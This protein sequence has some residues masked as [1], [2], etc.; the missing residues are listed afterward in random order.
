MLQWHKGI[1]TAIITYVL[2]IIFSLILLWQEKI[3]L[4]VIAVILFTVITIGI[5]FDIIG[6]AATAATEKSF[7]AMAA[8]KVSGSTEAIFLVRNADRVA[9]FCNDMIGDICG[10]VSGAMASALAV[11]LYHVLSLQLEL[12]IVALAAALTVGG[13]AVGKQ[14]AISEADRI[15]LLVGKGL[16]WYGDIFGKGKNKNNRQKKRISTAKK[17]QIKM[18]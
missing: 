14:Y 8:D 18:K 5:I 13:K 4:P 2:T 7:H 1:V 12:F 16:N 10:T 9:N 6:T 17:R 11:R 15:I 3:N